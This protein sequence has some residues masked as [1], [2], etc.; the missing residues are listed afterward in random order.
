MRQR[1]T[2]GENTSS[3][4][5]TLNRKPPAWD[6]K[7]RMELMEKKFRYAEIC[8]FLHTKIVGVAAYLRGARFALVDSFF[9]LKLFTV[10]ASYS[11]VVAFKTS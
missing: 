4:N 5:T 2:V 1:T 8:S 3:T 9:V 6:M 11:T 10:V 7:G